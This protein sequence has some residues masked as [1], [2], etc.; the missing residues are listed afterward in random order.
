[1]RTRAT[2][3]K[4]SLNLASSSNASKKKEKKEER[5]RRRRQ[6]RNYGSC[7]GCSFVDGVFAP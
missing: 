3:E 2:K 4:F 1:M 7:H 6:P 5:R